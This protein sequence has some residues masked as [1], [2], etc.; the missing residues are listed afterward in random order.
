MPLVMYTSVRWH[1][2]NCDSSMKQ[3]LQLKNHVLTINTSSNKRPDW[4]IWY[5]KL[6]FSASSQVGPAGCG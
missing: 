1:S 3:Y 5:F 6:P 2:L 4:I